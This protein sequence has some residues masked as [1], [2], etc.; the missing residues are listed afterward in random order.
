MYRGL[1]RRRSEENNT[2]IETAIEVAVKSLKD[3]ASEE[4]R[5][6]F[7][8]EAAIMGQFNHVNIVRILGIVFDDPAHV[9]IT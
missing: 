6:K 2:V 4:E 3:E 1:W 7:L 5:V 9:R 8:K